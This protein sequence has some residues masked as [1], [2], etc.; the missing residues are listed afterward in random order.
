MSQKKARLIGEADRVTEDKS[1][2]TDWVRGRRSSCGLA[3]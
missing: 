1:V 2:R 3:T